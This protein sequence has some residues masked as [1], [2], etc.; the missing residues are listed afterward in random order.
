MM[1]PEIV[2]SLLNLCFII[3]NDQRTGTAGALFINQSSCG[4][5]LPARNLTNE[6]TY[7]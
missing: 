1:E 2:S 7:L 4:S 3:F 5:G 6:L